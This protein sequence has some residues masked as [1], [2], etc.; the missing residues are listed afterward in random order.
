MPTR[1][2]CCRPATTHEEP[3]HRAGTWRTGPG[4]TF[5]DRVLRE[6]RRL[7]IL[8]TSREPL[9]ITGE[10]LWL[11]EPLALPEGDASPSEIASSPAVRLPRDRAGAVRKDFRVDEHTLSTMVRIC[12]ALDGIPLAIELAAARLRT[13][14]IEQLANRLDDRFRLLTSGSRTALPRHKTLR[15][16]VDWSWELLTDAERT[17]LPRLSVFSGGASLEAAERVCADGAVEQE[18]VLELLRRWPRNRC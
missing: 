8:A 13:M 5:A 18:Q 11:V 4:T 10:A 16:V 1:T 3:V 12:R 17:V 15:A 6:C 9:G 2:G 7:R 14:S